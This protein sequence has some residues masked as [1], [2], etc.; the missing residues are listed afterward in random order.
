MRPPT[1]PCAS[2]VVRRGVSHEDQ[3]Q[4][5][6]DVVMGESMSGLMDGGWCVGLEGGQEGLGPA[7]HP[8]RGDGGS[9]ARVRR[10]CNLV[11]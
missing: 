5:A 1:E 11:G 4:E 8:C 7:G 6:K 10:V 3:E 2:L 9:G